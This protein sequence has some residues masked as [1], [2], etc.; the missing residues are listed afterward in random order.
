MSDFFSAGW[1]V[2]IAV[3]TVAG[4]L[5]CLALL[6][7]T[8]RAQTNPR[9]D[10]GHVWDHDL[11]ELNNPMPRWWIVLFV[12]TIVFA[13]TYLVLYPGLGSSKGLLGWTSADA[14][15]DEQASAERQ[16]AGVYATYASTPFPDLARDK[17]A[18]AIGE[19]LFMNNC[20]GCHG[21]DARGGK[22]FPNLTD[23]DWLYGGS[24]ETI[25]E[26]ITHGRQGTMPSM[27]AAVG[28]P[29]EVRNVAEYVLS[30]SRSPHDPMAAAAGQTK[31]IVCAG[32]HGID[33]KGNQAIGAPNLTDDIWLHGGGRDA[34]IR[35]VNTGKTNIMPAQEHR[36][37]AAQIHVVGAYVWNLSHGGAKN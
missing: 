5:G 6:V 35:M 10:T 36:L 13:F 16:L 2:Y 8:G 24:P 11:R 15:R 18:M 26:T 30:L 12:I 27:A 34:I 3:A 7:F 33:G 22:G 14:Y 31:F 20:S 25:V 23:N 1:S 21:S 19:R 29:D 4:L 9:D 32:C 28:S 37:T 17:A